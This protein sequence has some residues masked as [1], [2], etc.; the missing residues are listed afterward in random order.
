VDVGPVGIHEIP[1]VTVAEPTTV[2]GA[3][4]LRA[5]DDLIPRNPASLVLPPRPRRRTMS[6]L[7]AESLPLLHR[8]LD[9][10]AQLRLVFDMVRCLR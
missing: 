5:R 2:A 9:D 10:T 3:V 1:F 4:R 8:E 7:A 6:A